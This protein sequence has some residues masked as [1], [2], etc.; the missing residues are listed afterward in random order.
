[1]SDIDFSDLSD[2]II[3]KIPEYL[4]GV[5]T[6]RIAMLEEL[7]RRQVELWG[8]NDFYVLTCNGR[9]AELKRLKESL[10]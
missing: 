9:I 10:K 4:K 8:E 2:V 5:L 3:N 1:M 6:N 7:N